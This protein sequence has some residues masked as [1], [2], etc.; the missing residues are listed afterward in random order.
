MKIVYITNARLPTEKAHG[1]QILRMCEAFSKLGFDVNVIHPWRYQSNSEHR[2]IK[3]EDYFN[4]RYEVNIS[5]IPFLDVYLLRPFL[6]RVIFRMVSF[7]FAFFWG[8]V[9]LIIAK[10][11]KPDICI[12]RENTPF[13]FWFISKFGMKTILE[14]HDLPPKFARKIFKLAVKSNSKCSI[15]AVTKKL[16]RDLEKTLG[17]SDKK[18]NTLH[19][20]VELDLFKENL[21][22]ND[23]DLGVTYCGSLLPDKGVE[24]L[25]QASDRLP[26]IKFT[27]IGGHDSEI[28]SYKNKWKKCYLDNI[29]FIGYVNPKYVPEYLVKSEIL[30]LPSTGKTKKSSL[31]TSSLKLFEYLG[32]AKAIIA[33][34]L[35]AVREV[36]VHRKTAYLVKPDDPDELAK[37]IDILLKDKPLKDLL[38]KNAKKLARKYSW[39]GRAKRMLEESNIHIK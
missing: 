4:L 17:L 22:K 26:K 30:V 31:Y 36:L 1:I 28:E 29:N 9:S 25:L 39:F 24:V 19:D 14:F 11:M 37:A 18:V 3:V 15:F 10:N 35:P 21:D 20:G 33:S 34:D 32:A 6:P 27:I 2:N 38:E 13:S 5:C 12:M 23:G 8:L 7:L 16:A